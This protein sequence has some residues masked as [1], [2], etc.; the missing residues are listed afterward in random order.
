MDVVYRMN[1]PSGYP[2]AVFDSMI[3]ANRNLFERL[4][5]VCRKYLDRTWLINFDMDCCFDLVWVEDR[6]GKR[7]HIFEVL[8]PGNE[9]NYEIVECVQSLELK[10]IY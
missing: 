1:H 2:V 5:L 8:Q 9:T 4:A 7:H 10:F 3:L 6:R